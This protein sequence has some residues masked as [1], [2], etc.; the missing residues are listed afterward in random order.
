MLLI[1]LNHKI[2][3]ASVNIICNV[4]GRASV[5]CDV[6]E[7]EQVFVNLVG[8]AIDAIETAAVRTIHINVFDKND[9]LIVQV[10]D[11]G[12]GIDPQIRHRLFEPFFTTKAIGKGTGL[13]LSIVKGILDRHG[14]TIR[15]T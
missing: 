5:F 4:Q 8:N 7:I 6:L 1:M 3:Q 2:T 13:G 12:K 11:S 15:F 10:Q 14:A 9:R